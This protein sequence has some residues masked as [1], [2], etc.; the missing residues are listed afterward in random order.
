MAGPPPQFQP[1]FM[2]GVGPM[3]LPPMGFPQPPP[4]VV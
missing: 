1:P 4:Y 2:G 3:P